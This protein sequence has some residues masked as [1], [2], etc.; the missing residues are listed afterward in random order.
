MLGQEV[1]LE[2]DGLEPLMNTHGTLIERRPVRN[3]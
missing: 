2:D 3:S 1:H